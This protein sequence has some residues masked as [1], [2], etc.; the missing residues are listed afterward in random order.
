MCRQFCHNF[1]MFRYYYSRMLCSASGS[2]LCSLRQCI[3]SFLPCGFTIQFI[4][5]VDSLASSAIHTCTNST[6]QHTHRHSVLWI[7]LMFFCWLLVSLL[8][9][10]NNNFCSFLSF[11]R[12]PRQWYQRILYT[13]QEKREEF[14]FIF[15]FR[16]FLFIFIGKRCRC[17][18]P[19]LTSSHSVC[20]PFWYFPF[21]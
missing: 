1:C 5:I 18:Q 7:T 2:V 15:R 19:S 20:L 8:F 14:S 21:H 17:H 9:D 3:Y 16:K 13:R 6:T 11:Y 10:V 12:A 4:F